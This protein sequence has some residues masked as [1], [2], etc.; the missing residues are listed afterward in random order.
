M[1]YNLPKM[2]ILDISGLNTSKVKTLESTFENY[3]GDYF[4][5]K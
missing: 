1:F 3:K 5:F 2:D 4:K